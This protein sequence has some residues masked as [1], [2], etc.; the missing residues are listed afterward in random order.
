[1]IQETDLDN[2]FGKRRPGPVP[3]KSARQDQERV[4]AAALIFLKTLLSC[5][6]KI[7][8]SDDII[9]SISAHTCHGLFLIPAHDRVGIPEG[10]SDLGDMEAIVRLFA[11][12]PKQF[13]G[14]DGWVADIKKVALELR[15]TG[16]LNY[17]PKA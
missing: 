12:F 15:K 4:S 6:P 5:L 10:Q 1:M 14:M 8:E 9:R 17:D 16:K 2:L 7:Q 11:K 13:D 3:T